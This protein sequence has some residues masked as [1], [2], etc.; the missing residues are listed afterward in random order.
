M[1]DDLKGA[2]E[3]YERIKPLILALESR[4]AL[5]SLTARTLNDI[6][7]TLDHLLIGIQMES[8][9]AA[10]AEGARYHYSQAREHLREWAINSYEIIAGRA[11][12]TSRQRLLAAGS[13]SRARQAW[14]SHNDAVKHYD[15]GRADRTAD[16]NGSLVHFQKAAELA[17]QAAAEVPASQP[18]QRFLMWATIVFVLTTLLNIVIA[19]RLLLG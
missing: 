16:A 13:L 3:D 5:S 18:G 17:M 8:V 2:A 19:F 11:L 4:T 14:E 9:A 10:D 6:R 15:A 12:Q 1:H 7:H